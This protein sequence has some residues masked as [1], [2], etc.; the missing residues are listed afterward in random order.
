MEVVKVGWSGG[1]DSTC[2]VMHHLQRGDKVKAVCFIP[3]FT[4]EIPLIC[5]NHY[6][7]IMNTANTFR[8]MGAEVHIVTG[9]CYYDR[10]RHRAT[11]GKFK[12]RIFGFPYFNRGQ[13]HFKR[14]SKQKALLACDVGEFDYEDI[15][16]AADETK[17]QGQLNDKKRSIL[18][19]LGIT[20]NDA[21]RFCKENGLLSPH[22][23]V[24]KRDG[25][26]LCPNAPERERQL[27]FNDYPEAIPL[28]IELQE[29]VKKERP[30]NFPL[31]NYG[32]FIEDRR[33]GGND[34][35]P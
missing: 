18:C 28:V 1:K 11:R 27:W 7:F 32:W 19:E 14:D 6:S 17:R 22:Y 29:L 4:N 30:D 5:K 12:G 15:G 21:I 9:E 23:A 10:V 16:I 2:A 8:S 31:R 34:D 13:C 3:M 25:C 20:G 33:V 35:E 26:A 24:N